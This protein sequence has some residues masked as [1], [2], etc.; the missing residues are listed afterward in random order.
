MPAEHKGAVRENYQWKV[1]EV[2]F[3]TALVTLLIAGWECNTKSLEAAIIGGHL[4]SGLL[5]DCLNM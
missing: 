5:F 2:A 1:S 4:V 3:S